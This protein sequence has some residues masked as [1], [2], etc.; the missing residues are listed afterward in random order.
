MTVAYAYRTDPVG[1]IREKYKVPD[2]CEIIIKQGCVTKDLLNPFYPPTFES[3]DY[4]NWMS[5]LDEKT[6]ALCLTKHGKIYSFDDIPEEE[7]PL[8]P[9]CRCWLDSMAAAMAGTATQDGMDGA[10]V[11]I[12]DTGIL[13]E[14]YITKREAIELGWISLIGNLGKVAPGKMIGGGRYFNRN[15]HLPQAP[16]RIWYEAD[17]NYNGG[18]RNLHRL[19]YSNDGLV[20]VTYDHYFTFIQIK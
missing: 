12:M 18:Y 14:N 17:I 11:S 16:G 1:Y 13:P 9:N 6:C 3:T 15:G 19:L 10:D 4:R 20:F 2:D 7:P 8:H 5:E